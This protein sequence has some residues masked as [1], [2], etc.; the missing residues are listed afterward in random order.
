MTI[1]KLIT[2]FRSRLTLPAE[3]AV[4]PFV[5]GVIGNLGSGKSTLARMLA[6]K[7]R[8]SVVITADSARFLLKEQEM[9]WGDNV[10][11]IVRGVADGLLEDGYAVILDGSNAEAR[12][13]EQTGEVAG[14]L[15]MP[16]RYVRMKVPYEVC[17]ERLKAKYDDALWQSSFERFRVGPTDKM[18]INLKQ[19]TTFHDSLKDED[20]EGLVGVVNND[21]DS[22]NLQR[23]AESVA[24]RILKSLA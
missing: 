3:K 4:R 9:P 23:Q 21:G 5:L 6:G 22:A 24:E 8:G 13:R 16:V 15:G 11:A 20:I 2:E 10:R 17:R 14:R 12:E 18:L 7:I 19:R 1:D